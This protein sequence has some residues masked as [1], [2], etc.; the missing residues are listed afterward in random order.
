ML[1]WRALFYNVLITVLGN[2]FN[3]YCGCYG[4]AALERLYVNVCMCLWEHV[5]NLPAHIWVAPYVIYFMSVKYL[6]QVT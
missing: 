1:F 6:L 4:I 5:Y 3:S 2:I